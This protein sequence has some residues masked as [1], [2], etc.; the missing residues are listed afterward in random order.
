MESSAWNIDPSYLNKNIDSYDDVASSIFVDDDKLDTQAVMM[1]HISSYDSNQ[2]LPA[3]N[4]DFRELKDLD[5]NF[6]N[7]NKFYELSKKYQYDMV[8]NNSNDSNNYYNNKGSKFDNQYHLSNNTDAQNSI[9][10]SNVFSQFFPAKKTNSQNLDQKTFSN[11]INFNSNNDNTTNDLAHPANLLS[12]LEYQKELNR[13]LQNQLRLNQ[14]EKKNYDLKETSSNEY[15][16]VKRNTDESEFGMNDDVDIDLVDWQ[17]YNG[18]PTKKH[19]RRARTHRNMDKHN[20]YFTPLVN[21]FKIESPTKNQNQTNSNFNPLQLFQDDV[22]LKNESDFNSNL[23][24]EF[25]TDDFLSSPIKLNDNNIPFTPHSEIMTPALI[26]P[27][28]NDNNDT[29]VFNNDAQDELNASLGLGLY[30]FDDEQVKDTKQLFMKPPPLNAFPITKK[31]N[32]HTP[33]NATIKEESKE[34]LELDGTLDFLNEDPNLKTP[35]KRN[36]QRHSSM[37]YGILNNRVHRE[38]PHLRH[39]SMSVLE[40]KNNS[41][42]KEDYMNIFHKEIEDEDEEQQNNTN[43]KFGISNTPSP[44]L[45]SQGHFEKGKSP[46]FELHSTKNGVLQSPTRTTRKLTTL[47]IGSIDKYVKQLPDKLFECIYPNCNKIFKRRYNIRSHIQTHLEDRP[48]ACDFEGCTKAFVR[49]HDLLRHKKTHAEKTHICPCGK[50]FNRED[51]LIVHRSRLICDGGK[52]YANVV[53]KRSPRKRG[54]PKKNANTSENSSPIK[55]KTTRAKDGIVVFKIENQLKKSTHPA[56][57][58]PHNNIITSDLLAYAS[59]TSQP[60]HQTAP[61]SEPLDEFLTLE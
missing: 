33:P 44:V 20:K 14:L 12:E 25:T 16:S 40:G 54:R 15:N 19:D 36:H 30:T 34:I 3:A 45:K 50:K 27:S 8:H 49:N 22:F 10:S 39:P 52:K 18:S 11:D 42:I 29:E 43:N 13:K 32:L 1:N 60:Q 35:Q 21:D 6:L 55:G 24:T 4:G 59:G 56:A 47:P 23:N 38:A 2:T 28:K 41:I 53:I 26:S 48:Y 46:K 51:A 31:K 17:V 9:D 5:N 57:A 58:V 61:S 37:Q 7:V